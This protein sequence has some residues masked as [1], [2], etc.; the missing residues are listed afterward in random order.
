[1]EELGWTGSDVWYAHGIHFNDEELKILAETKTGVAH[2]P[3]PINEAF[4]RDSVSYPGNAEAWNS[5]GT[6]S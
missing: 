2:C 4:L 3:I 6:G 5:R 1:M